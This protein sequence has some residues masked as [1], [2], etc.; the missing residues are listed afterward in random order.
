MWQWYVWCLT[1]LWL[2]DRVYRQ[3]VVLFLYVIYHIM[4]NEDFNVPLVMKNWQSESSEWILFHTT[5]SQKR[6]TQCTIGN[7]AVFT[8]DASQN[9][10]NKNTT[11][12][13][14]TKFAEPR[15]CNE[16][17]DWTKVR[18]EFELGSSLIVAGEMTQTAGSKREENFCIVH[19]RR[20]IWFGRSGA[21]N[22]LMRGK[23]CDTLYNKRSGMTTVTVQK[24]DLS[25]I[26]SADKC[27]TESQRYVR[28]ILLV[29]LYFKTP[30]SAVHFDV[31]QSTRCIVYF[32]CFYH[33]L[34]TG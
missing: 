21:L 19:R 13:S 24:C 27:S 10:L 31:F 34:S 9:L 20:E 33:S 2:R 7:A 17:C 25:W 8:N 26:R 32:Y 3:C 23:N 29:L 12:Q 6:K 15:W 28:T 18:V 1:F 30:V 11:V 5:T 22:L 4:V 16:N 14:W